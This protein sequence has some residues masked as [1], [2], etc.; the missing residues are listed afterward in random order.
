A[1]QLKSKNL[2]DLPRPAAPQIVL[3]FEENPK[4]CPKYNKKNMIAAIIIP[5]NHQ[6]HGCNINSII[7]F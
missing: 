3:K 6:D 7:Y 4:D 2:A 1:F 5:E